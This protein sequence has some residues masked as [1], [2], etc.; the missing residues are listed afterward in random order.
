MR[1]A[2]PADAS[3]VALALEPR[4]VLAPRDEVVHLLDVD[5]AVPL[6]L[7]PE[8]LAALLDRR[9]PDL[10]RDR[11]LAAP[12]LE[13]RAERP[14]GAADAN[15]F[16]ERGF[17]CVNLANGMTDI[18]TPDERISVDDLTGMVD[19]TLALLEAARAD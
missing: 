8:L 1:D 7:P 17:Q 12:A 14:L 2:E 16:N 15:A 10:R 9:R 11:R 5:A 18:H 6:D 3:F 4:G 13:R 19:V